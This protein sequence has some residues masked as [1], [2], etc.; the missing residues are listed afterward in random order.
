MKLRN[1]IERA[2]GKQWNWPPVR[3][4]L[5][6]GRPVYQI[7]WEDGTSG[8]YYIDWDAEEIEET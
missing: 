6:G 3:I 8:D 2:I 5:W 7:D 4:G 1:W